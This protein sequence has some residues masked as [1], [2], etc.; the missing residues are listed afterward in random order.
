M[1]LR[2]I[3]IKWKLAVPI[4]ILVTL[5]VTV[6]TLVTGYQTEAIVLHEA[7]HSTLP[8]YRDTV[9]NA[10]TTMMIAGNMKQSKGPFVDQMRTLVDLRV[11]RS[12][13]LDKDFGR[14]E[15]SDYASDDIEKDVIQSGKEKVVIE[16]EAIR[17]VYPYIAKEKFMG[18]NCLS[19]HSVSEGTVLGAVSIRLPLR[20]SFA[21][22]RS[23]QYLFALLGLLGVV[24]MA[25][26]VPVLIHLVHAPIKTLIAKVRRVGEGYTDTSLHIEGKDE[27]A[28]MSQSVDLVVK[29]FSR[30]LHSIIEASSGILPAVR[31][32]K[33]HADATLEGARKQSG[34]AHMI[35]TA[36]EEMT[37]TII[38]IARNAAE[39]AETSTEAMEIAEGGKHITDISAETIK[40][41]N[42]STVSL[43]DMIQKQSQRAQEIGKIVTVIKDIADQTNLLALNAAIEAARAGDQGRGF[44]VVADEVRK[45]AERTIKATAEISAEIGTVQSES[46]RTAES[47]AEASKGVTKSTGHILNL[48]NVLD[49]IVESISRVKDQ[50]NQIA[51]AVEEQSATASEVASNIESTSNISRELEGLSGN[52]AQEVE[53]LAEIAE[54][55]SQTTANIKT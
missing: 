27:I 26:I 35:A 34:Q 47:M 33:E 31:N 10:L 55:L 52:V 7:E 48:K 29:H 36:A 19:C 54:E 11:I 5:G 22:I 6:T 50:I 39:S 41:V 3:S 16:G 23:M 37:Q 21:R 20:E 44:A 53:K 51:V 30:M 32:V 49:T 38:D 42:A 13:V 17:G 9:L 24:A 14:G 8:G 46:A 4:I 1:R 45:L 15:A 40:E 2:D 28:Q 18:K 43:A 25:V 12:E